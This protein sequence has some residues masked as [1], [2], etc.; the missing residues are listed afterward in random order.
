[1]TNE[2]SGTVAENKEPIEQR[3]AEVLD[4]NADVKVE[5]AQKLSLRDALEVGIEAT[6][7]PENSEISKH[8]VQRVAK[9]DKQ[10]K[11]SD[12][13]SNNI[14]KEPV[15]K[16][17]A[18][19]EWSTEEREDFKA[20]S[21]KQ[22]E[23][24]LRLYKGRLN[25]LE[26]IK[27]EAADLQW[28]KDL[29]KEVTPFVKVRGDKAPTH[30]Q[31]INA[32]K[33]V[34]E[35]DAD[36]KGAV[37]SILRAK[38]LEVPKDLLTSDGGANDVALKQAIAPLQSELNAIKMKQAQEE[39][40]RTQSLLSSAW[41]AFE[42]EKNA[43]GSAK[44]PD[45][46]NDS[47]L[48]LASNIGSLVNGVSD[49]SKQFIANVQSRKPNATFTTI[50][51]EAYRYCGGKVEDSPAKTQTTQMQLIKSNRAAASVPGRGVAPGNTGQP[52]KYKTYREAAAA[53]LAELKEAE[54]A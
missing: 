54:G 46:Q 37:A 35:V 47:G 3:H 45:L 12:V 11:A 49:L 48:S 20:L 15:R 8:Q 25:K 52:K 7:K 23:A 44:Y 33:M 39:A 36:T 31:I 13:K 10:P 1:M 28:A 29:V 5:E 32:L 19:G 30:Q 22:Q 4:N 26:E 51:E 2:E 43:S 27:R 34:N 50:L 21:P 6:K 16:F 18:P 42:S 17:E 38:G 40:Q 53:A 24:T 14:A 41:Q 9:D